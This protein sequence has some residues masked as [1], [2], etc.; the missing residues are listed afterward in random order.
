MRKPQLFKILFYDGECYFLQ[1][2]YYPVKGLLGIKIKSIE[3][4]RNRIHPKSKHFLS[5]VVYIL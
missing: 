3:N 2:H 4:N 5:Q 1:Y